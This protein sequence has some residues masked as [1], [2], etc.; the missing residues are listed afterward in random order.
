[1]R[2]IAFILLTGLAATSSVAAD[3]YEYKYQQDTQQEIKLKLKDNGDGTLAQ[4]VMS[5]STRPSAF[6]SRVHVSSHVGAATND[7]VLRTVASPKVM[8]VTS[9]SLSAFNSSTTNFGWVKIN[10]GASTV[11]TSLLIPTSIVGANA[12]A[13]HMEQQFEEPLQFSTDFRVVVAS[14]TVTYAASFQGYEE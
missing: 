9:L 10:D 14:G 6:N 7:F 4:F 1:M 2:R 13:S 3:T 11:K 8:Y 5:I 12:Q